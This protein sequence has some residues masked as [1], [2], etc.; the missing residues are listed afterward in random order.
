M[1]ETLPGALSEE[2]LYP[3]D[4][5]GC[6]FDPP[7]ELT[8][9]LDHEPVSRVRIWD[10]STPWLVTRHE[11]ARAVL[12]D[13]RFSADVRRDGYPPVSAAQKARRER[14]RPFIA[15]DDPEHARFRKMLIGEFTM[16][17]TESLRPMVTEV[18]DELLDRMAAGPRPV[19]LVSAFTLPLP[20]MVICRMLGVPYAD[21]EFFQRI[22]ASL[23]NNRTDPQVALAAGDELTGYLLRL[24]RA[25]DS[26]P[27]DDLISRLVVRRV[28][29]GEITDA[30]LVGMLNL[31]LIAGHETTANQLALGTLTL[32]RHPDQ[33]AELRATDDPEVVKGAVE[34]LLRLLTVVHSGRRRVATEDVEIGGVTIHAG[35][36]VVVAGEVANRD[37]EA[38]PEPAQLDIHR[39]ARH[40]VA[41][42]YGVHQCLGQ[43]LA[44]LE[45]QIAYP[46]LLKRFP[47]LAVTEKVED[48]AFRD[49]ML[50]YGL[51]ELPVT[52]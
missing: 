37:P 32:L 13:Q 42:G 30:E 29:T 35:D 36:G 14:S 2:P 4:R 39:P 25:K 9:L 19:D 41:F 34:E 27:G 7:A 43:P 50:V 28:R 16:R 6:P 10:G 33:A 11:D 5:G 17:H 12:S 20:S 23:L 21:H 3:M 22:S 49:E 38:F 46:A 24:V 47:D 1:S 26:E 8:D 45:L 18:V 52:W 48:L 15:M 44:R 31:L 51:H 40:H